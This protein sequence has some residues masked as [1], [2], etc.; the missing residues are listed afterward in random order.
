M[1]S[2]RVSN[3]GALPVLWVEVNDHS[4]V[5]GYEAG[6]VTGLGPREHREWKTRAC[7]VGADSTDW[8]HYAFTLET[9]SAS[10][11]PLKELPDQATVSRL[12]AHN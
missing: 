5:P 11:V 9:P 3:A 10:S 4:D 1:E 6:I 2:F 7:V 8:V 12:S